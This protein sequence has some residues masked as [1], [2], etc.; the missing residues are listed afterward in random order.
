MPRYYPIMLNVRGRKTVVIG[1]DAIAAQKAAALSASGAQVTVMSPVPG[2]EVQELVDQHKVELQPEAYTPGVLAGAFVVVAATNDQALIEAIWQETQER[3]QLVNIVDV[4]SY[5]NYIVPSILRRGQLTIAVSTEGAS[6]SLAKRIRQ[7]LEQDFPPA[8]ETY[9]QLA[10]IVRAYMR[11]HGLSY[12]RRDEFFGDFFSSDIL[13]LLEEGEQ[14]QAVEHTVELL[15]HYAVDIPTATIT[16]DIRE[17]VDH[18]D[19]H[20]TL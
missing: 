4:P 3:G 18:N 9:M 15:R 5:C 2:P 6:P 7:R 11:S 12:D 13:A 1:G 16:A 14:A 20:A 10:T 19:N 17:A 8:Y